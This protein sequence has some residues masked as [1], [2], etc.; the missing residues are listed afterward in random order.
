MLIQ[1][2]LAKLEAL[3]LFGMLRALHNQLQSPDCASLSFEERL[4]LLVDRE[5]TEQETQKV[6]ARLKRAQMRQPV[7]PEDVDFRHPRGL[8]R[9]QFVALC[10]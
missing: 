3:H 7:A 10:A 2:T 8:N 6:A 1:P 5:A 4:G 9:A